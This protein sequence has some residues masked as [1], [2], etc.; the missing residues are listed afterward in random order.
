MDNSFGKWLSDNAPVTVAV[1]CHAAAT[2]RWSATVNASLKSITD[3][4]LRIDKELEKRDASINA[5]GGKL[6][7]LKERVIILEHEKSKNN[8]G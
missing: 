7:G 1:L 8:G 4:L 2:I 6:D 5:I 3:A